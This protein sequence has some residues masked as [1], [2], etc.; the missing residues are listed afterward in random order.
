MAA[1][2][3]CVGWLKGLLPGALGL[4]AAPMVAAEV[5]TPLFLRRLRLRQLRRVV[6]AATRAVVR[7]PLRLG[8]VPSV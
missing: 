5:S 7:S 4:T 3:T 6:K 1:A 8:Q 2:A